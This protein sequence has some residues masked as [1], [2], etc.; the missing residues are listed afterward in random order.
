MHARFIP[1]SDG[2]VG[3]VASPVKFFCRNYNLVLWD[4][5]DRYARRNENFVP[6]IANRQ[7][8]R[9]PA[10]IFTLPKNPISLPS[11]QIVMPNSN[12]KPCDHAQKLTTPCSPANPV[13]PKFKTP[14]EPIATSNQHINKPLT[15]TPPETPEP[16]S[17][18]Q[19]TPH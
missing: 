16:A 3:G 2:T 14:D 11:A 18:S 15:P 8:A 1:G 5:L 7:A 6:V 4:G 13:P 9:N 10:P 19:P 12:R 17:R